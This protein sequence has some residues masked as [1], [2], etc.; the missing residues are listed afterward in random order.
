MPPDHHTEGPQLAELPP[1]QRALQPPQSTP[2][3]ASLSEGQQL[4][5]LPD[6][7]STWMGV[8]PV[9]W[10][11]A[12]HLWGRSSSSSLSVAAKELRRSIP[13]DLTVSVSILLVPPTVIHSSHFYISYQAV[14]HMHL[15]ALTSQSLLR[16]R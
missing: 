7:G 9:V 11:G 5:Q 3:S 4:R 2:G 13:M 6:T 12:Q 16:H 14:T 1:V 8:V 10:I 15:Y